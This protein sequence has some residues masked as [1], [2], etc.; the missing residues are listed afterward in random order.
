MQL[1]PLGAVLTCVSLMPSCRKGV[2]S[3]RPLRTCRRPWRERGRPCL[4]SGCKAH[5][6]AATFTRPGDNLQRSFGNILRDVHEGLAMRPLGTGR[7]LC[8]EACGTQLVLFYLVDL[9]R[10]GHGA[11]VRVAQN[12]LSAALLGCAPLSSLMPNHQCIA[13]IGVC[14]PR[15]PSV[16][17]I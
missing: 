4:G 11:R 6:V 15:K 9:W 10:P 1:L 5:W 8:C 16:A 7:L 13:F 14:L 2:W 3:R 12:S 17:S